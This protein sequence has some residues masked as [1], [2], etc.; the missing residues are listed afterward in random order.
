MSE[1]I[2]WEGKTFLLI[3]AGNWVCRVSGDAV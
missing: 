2:G 3:E 1:G